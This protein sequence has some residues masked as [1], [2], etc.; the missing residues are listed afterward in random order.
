MGVHKRFT[1]HP[2]VLTVG[3]EEFSDDY[4]AATRKIFKFLLGDDQHMIEELVSSASQ[5]DTNRWTAAELDS[6][7][8]VTDEATSAETIQL[9]LSMRNE[10]LVEQVLGFDPDLG[11][12]VPSV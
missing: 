5:Y 11:Y 3:L 6:D 7:A 9:F 12:E 10:S 2:Y 8:H 1:S 4:D